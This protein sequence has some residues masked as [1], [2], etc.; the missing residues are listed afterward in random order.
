MRNT[1]PA[2]LILAMV[3]LLSVAGLVMVSGDGP[4]TQGATQFTLSQY[5]DL[6]CDQLQYNAQRYSECYDACKM[7]KTKHPQYLDLG[8]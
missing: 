1:N 2:V 4:Q 3:T 6:E 8:N 5:C 7:F